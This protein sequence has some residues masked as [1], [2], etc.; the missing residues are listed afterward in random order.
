M[1]VFYNASVFHYFRQKRPWVVKTPATLATDAKWPVPRWSESIRINSIRTDEAVRGER[2]T[3]GT[4][5][6]KGKPHPKTPM[7]AML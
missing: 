2:A 1:R 3:M 6:F 7:C 5:P 4:F